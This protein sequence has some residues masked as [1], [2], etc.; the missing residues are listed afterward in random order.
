MAN[1]QFGLILRAQFPQEDDMQL[2]F[3]ELLEQVRLADKLEY[4]S[5]TTGMHYSSAPLQLLQQLPFLARA[6]AEAPRLRVNFGAIILP[7]HK[8][9]DVAESLATMDVMS[10]GKVIFSA[11]LGYRD[12]ESLAFGTNARDRVKRFEEN[13][14]AIKRLWTEDTVDM[15]GS[16][17]ELRGAS[18]SVKPVQK[19]H[20]P[21][22]IAANADAA[23]RRAARLGDCWYVNPHN[24]LDTILRQVDVYKQ[25]LEQQGKPFP[26][27]FPARREVFVAKSREEAVRLCRPFLATKYEAY[28]AWGQDRAMPADDGISE[29]FDELVRDRFLLGSPDEVA[30]QIIRLHRQTGINHLIMSVQW[31]GMP[32]SMVLEVIET[33]ARDVFPKVRAA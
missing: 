21:I 11:G 28:R 8:P 9:L 13:L 33:L 24:R 26:S 27:E 2:R 1:V 14:I 3:Q 15:V 18:V 17:F 6:M 32:Q 5:L 4:S 12:V 23:I 20:P 31:P 25:A 10:G 16:H 7:L 29:N 19:P 22:W 30:D